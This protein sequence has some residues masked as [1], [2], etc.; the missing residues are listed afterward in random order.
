MLTLC[1]VSASSVA[2]K[3]Q[4]GAAAPRLIVRCRPSGVGVPRLAGLWTG[5]PRPSRAGCPNTPKASGDPSQ[6]CLGVH[7]RLRVIF[8][9][10][11]LR[12]TI[13]WSCARR[14]NAHLCRSPGPGVLHISWLPTG[15]KRS[16]LPSSCWRGA[17]ARTG[18][19]LKS[20]VLVTRPLNIAQGKP[21]C[22]LRRAEGGAILSSKKQD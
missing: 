17:V 3:E 2:V 12:D 13:N 4:T 5:E 6:L 21:K 7:R 10:T 15:A 20:S 8:T 18:P 1:L 9:R 11:A 16:I 19:S 22:I 14:V